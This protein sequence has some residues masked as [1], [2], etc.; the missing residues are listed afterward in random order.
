MA[1]RHISKT[2]SNEINVGDTVEIINPDKAYPTYTDWVFE[3]APDYAI[4]YS[5]GGEPPRGRYTVIAKAPHEF[6][7]NEM[8]YFLKENPPKNVFISL[9]EER[10]CYLMGEEGIVKVKE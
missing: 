7:E 4:L 2:I 9:R 3:N 6:F 8:L 10:P 1:K 5:Y